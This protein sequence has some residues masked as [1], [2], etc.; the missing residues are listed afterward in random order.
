[1]QKK[2]GTVLNEKLLFRARAYCHR[3]E[4]TI[5]HLLEEALNA[6]LRKK[7]H[8]AASF[9]AVE[10]SFGALKISPKVLRSMLEEDVYDA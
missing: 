4:T 8:T 3:E 1:M 9:S 2:F 10:A 5:S 7:E 6:Y